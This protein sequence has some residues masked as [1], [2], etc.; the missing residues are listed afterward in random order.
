MEVELASTGK[1]MSRQDFYEC[2]SI[3]VEVNSVINEGR[4]KD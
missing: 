2:D 4:L 1:M 3:S